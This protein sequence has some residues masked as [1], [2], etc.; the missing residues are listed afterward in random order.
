MLKPA[1]WK[2]SLTNRYTIHR[3]KS[4][5]DAIAGGNPVLVTVNGMKLGNPHYRAPGPRRHMVLLIGY[6]DAERK[7]VVHDPG[8]RFGASYEYPYDVMDG[9][10]E[11]Y[12]SGIRHIAP[13][14]TTAM[15]VVYKDIGR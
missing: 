1:L 2:L 15:I 10:L 3:S 7:F 13:V 9:A 12:P 6:D 11:D 5:R 4:I 14:R 8:T